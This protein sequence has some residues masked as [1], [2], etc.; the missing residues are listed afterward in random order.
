MRVYVLLLSL[1]VCVCVVESVETRCWVSD[2]WYYDYYWY[3]TPSPI[4][5]CYYYHIYYRECTTDDINTYPYC[6]ESLCG[7]PY[8]YNDHCLCHD[9]GDGCCRSVY[10]EVAL[11]YTVEGNEINFHC[12]ITYETNVTDVNMEFDWFVADDLVFQEQ[13][14]GSTVRSTM[15]QTYLE[16]KLGSLIRCEVGVIENGINI[17]RRNSSD[18]FAGITVPDS[19]D[20]YENDGPTSFNLELTIPF[21]CDSFNNNNAPCQVEIPITVSKRTDFGSY[22]DAVIQDQ[23]AAILTTDNAD[24]PVTVRVKATR[25][26]F[27]DGDGEVYLSFLPIETTNSKLWNG[28]AITDTITI[29]T[30]D[31]D[32]SSRK[33]CGNGD[34]HYSTFDGKHFDVYKPGE[35]VYYRHEFLPYEIQ[36]RLT[37]CGSVACT[38]G[39]VVRANDDV[40]IVDRC[41]VQEEEVVVYYRNGERY[42]YYRTYSKLT[43]KIIQNGDMTPGFRL[44]RTN[45]GY[46]YQVHFPNGAFVEASGG[47][48]LD[49]C[50]SP[51]SDD[52]GWLNGGLCGSYDGNYANDFLKGPFNSANREYLPARSNAHEF[53]DTWRLPEGN[54]LFYGEI[55]DSE[56]DRKNSTQIP[57]WP[58]PSGITE[59]FAIE[60]CNNL[61]LGSAAAKACEGVLFQNETDTFIENCVLD[62]QVLDD[63]NTAQSSSAL[64]R[65]QCEEIVSKDTTHWLVNDDGV[66][67]PPVAI[68][69]AL[70][71]ADCNG[72]GNCT[73][74][75]CVCS[76]GYGGTDCSVTLSEAPDVYRGHKNGLCDTSFESCSHVSIFG[77]KF[78]E[79]M[80][81][82]VTR[83]KISE[84]GFTIEDVASK[85]DSVFKTYE[86][87]Q[88]PVDQLS[89]RRRRDAD[90][91]EPIG[92]LISVSNDGTNESPQILVIIYNDNCDVCNGTDG[93]CRRKTNICI[94]DGDCY[95]LGDPLCQSGLSTWIIVVIAIGVVLVA[96]LVIGS[97]VIILKNP[98]P[99]ENMGKSKST[100]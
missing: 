30:Y 63:L 15:S 19:V 71:P 38:C 41:K 87:I 29:R 99:D 61:V 64:L 12:N 44:V 83:I 97:I 76:D 81:C 56:S 40:I 85:E 5:W 69:G 98:P 77:D 22:V 11:S 45:S 100:D 37:Q 58:T 96:F 54:N 91:V 78:V 66:I 32:R 39:L 16:G 60:Y 14:A 23:C 8:T 88:C 94:V 89:R 21:M 73:E 34:P 4:D 49:I 46:N 57:E 43:I 31:R 50:L 48:Y 9:T 27:S 65:D 95:D 25:D 90:P 3:T 24:G 47:Y 36:T 20:V 62:I 28:Y 10:D 1:C 84:T 55:D 13:V 82:H 53:S 67:V 17:G 52:Y 72:K 92:A 33:C 18:F 68:I 70:C 93:F 6:S 80:T 42:S 51:A 7:D 2:C 35:Y 26:F 59:Q 74:G 75:V 79:A 86:E